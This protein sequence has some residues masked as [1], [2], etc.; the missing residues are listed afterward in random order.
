[1]IASSKV[2]PKLAKIGE[3]TISGSLYDKYLVMNKIK[4]RLVGRLKLNPGT[5]QKNLTY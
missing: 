1:M 4:D 2:L 5:L 3:K